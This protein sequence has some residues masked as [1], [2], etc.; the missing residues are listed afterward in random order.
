MIARGP[1]GMDFNVA[2]DNSSINSTG[3]M[4]ITEKI[5]SL[6]ERIK[7]DVLLR[8]N[9]EKLVDYYGKDFM[10]SYA[11]LNYVIYIHTNHWYLMVISIDD[12]K[13]YHLDSHMTHES[14]EDRK[15]VIRT[16]G[17]IMS[18]V[19]AIVFYTLHITWGIQDMDHWDIL[20][21]RGIPNCECRY[22]SYA[23]IK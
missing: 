13:F 15:Q 17:C 5:R 20:Q 1:V 9:M 8:T 19:L 11:C 10:S 12:T 21:P 4:D 23:R 14:L 18:C 3:D 16:M 7:N 6:E 2:T 22:H